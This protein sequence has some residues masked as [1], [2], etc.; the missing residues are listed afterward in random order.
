MSTE[1]RKRTRGP[2]NNVVQGVYVVINHTLCKSNERV[3]CCKCL[4]LSRKDEVNESS[5]G[6]AFLGIHRSHV[7]L[8][9]PVFEKLMLILSVG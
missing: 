2:R 6:C 3:R 9:V 8:Q 7:L 4:T 5:Q 1:R